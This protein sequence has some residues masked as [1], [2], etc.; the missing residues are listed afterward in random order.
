[1]S[2]PNQPIHV[3]VLQART[4]NAA[5]HT[6][7]A[8]VRSALLALSKL[9]KRASIVGTRPAEAC[10]VQKSAEV[11]VSSGFASSAPVAAPAPATV[12]FTLTASGELALELG[13]I[14]DTLPIAMYNAETSQACAGCAVVDGCT[15]ADATLEGS[16]GA[17]SCFKHK[18]AAWEFLDCL[19]RV[20]TGNFLNCATVVL[21]GDK[22][23]VSVTANCSL[24]AA[25]PA[26]L[27]AELRR[28][29]VSPA[30]VALLKR[31]HPA[32][33]TRATARASA[34]ATGARKCRGSAPVA[35]P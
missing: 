22:T 1:M 12:A 23:L 34:R 10:P 20:S 29:S 27:Q 25:F 2:Q 8:A 14:H 33:C 28:G 26:L 24:A 7:V 19:A 31:R 16:L 5:V 11:S 15:S 30:G 21:P 32:C 3:P 9:F 6:V 35:S 17:L 4:M 18:H 13:V